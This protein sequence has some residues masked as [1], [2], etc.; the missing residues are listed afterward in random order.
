MAEMQQMR[1]VPPSVAK[2]KTEKV[3][4]MPKVKITGTASTKPR[5]SA[6]MSKAQPATASKPTLAA[7]KNP[8]SGK[9]VRVTTFSL[10]NPFKKDVKMVNERT[11]R[12]P[13]VKPK[14]TPK[15]PAK[16]VVQMPSKISPSKMTPA[17]KAKYLQNPERYDG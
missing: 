17:Q 6:S 14:T 12:K 2:K 15:A 7:K 16:K 1:K 8:V 5:V 10:L 11:T 4:E 3:K 13:V 9:T